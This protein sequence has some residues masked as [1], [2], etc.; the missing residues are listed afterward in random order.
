[1]RFELTTLVDIT[2][3]NARRGDDVYQC[4]QQQNFL[5]L[6]QSISLRAN[7]II[8]R[9]PEKQKQNISNM[10]FGKQYTGVHSVWSLQFEFENESQHSLEMLNSDINFVPVINNLDETA[11][12]ELSA[13]VTENP[14]ISNIFFI[15]RDK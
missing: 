12:F 9:K 11:D 6:F 7:P 5:T 8:T 15:E 4:N 13:F 14:Q 3:T 10:N 2:Q 1:M